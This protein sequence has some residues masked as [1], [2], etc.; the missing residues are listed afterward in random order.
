[1]RPIVTQFRTQRTEKRNLSLSRTEIGTSG[2][3]K[4]ETAIA[5]HNNS[6]TLG[7]ITRHGEFFFFFFFAFK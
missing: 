5:A 2:G 6:V 7:L 1:M 4:P 3:Y